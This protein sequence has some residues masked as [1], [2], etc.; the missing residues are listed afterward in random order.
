[1]PCLVAKLEKNFLS[2]RNGLRARSATHP[3]FRPGAQDRHGRHA[4]TH[5]SVNSV[6]HFDTFQLSL[7]RKFIN[8]SP[9]GIGVYITRCRPVEVACQITDNF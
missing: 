8:A 2:W 4:Q 1:V 3:A 5:P 7:R 6:S 9:E